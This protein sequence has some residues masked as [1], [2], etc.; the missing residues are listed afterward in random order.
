[1]KI[2]KIICAA[3]IMAMTVGMSS[4]AAGGES[5]ATVLF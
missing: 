5:A 3:M 2:R 4:C 1:M